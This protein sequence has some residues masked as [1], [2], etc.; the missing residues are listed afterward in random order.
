MKKHILYLA[1]LSVWVGGAGG[2]AS[3]A[4]TDLLAKGQRENAKLAAFH[5]ARFVAGTFQNV[6]A[7]YIDTT[8]VPYQPDDQDT[9]AIA[10]NRSPIGPLIQGL[11]QRMG[12][13]VMFTADTDPGQTVSINLRNIGRRAAIRMTAL[14]AGDVA[15]IQDRERR[16]IVAKQGTY[17]FKLPVDLFSDTKAKYGVGGNPAAGGSQSGG[18]APMGGMPGMGGAM[19]GSSGAPGQSMQASFVISG[20][21]GGG[22]A[23]QFL[24]NVKELAGPGAKVSANWITGLL[25]VTAAPAPLDRVRSFVNDFVQDALTQVEIQTTIAEVSLSDGQQFGIDW[26]RIVP[27]AGNGSV[28]FSFNNSNAVSSTPAFTTTITTASISSVVKALE[29]QANV[30]ILAK[31]RLLALNH[32]PANLFDGQQQP[33]LGSANTATTGLSGT[34][35]TGASLSYV[36]NGVSLSFLPN[37]LDN[38][39]V[40]LRIVPVLS[41]VAQF[42]DFSLNGTTLTGPQQLLR[43]VYMQ[44]LAQNG[45]TLILGG[46]HVSNTSLGHSGV[47]ILDR[48]PLLGKLFTGINDNGSQKELVLLVSTHVIPAPQHQTLIGET[49]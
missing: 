2:C 9:V 43:Q 34:V 1:L 10:S 14:A 45:K 48:I 11:A 31:P 4:N 32:T 36:L 12:Y 30:R 21:A 44:V 39:T 38:N 17:T 49:L 46:T 29:Q 33:Y 23:D 24:A 6:N 35:S 19:G 47:P 41:D 22:G 42:K 20:S 15:L 18:G 16:I 40:S 26:S 8:P 27:I 25:S 28:Q 37:I 13:S 5:R 3:T 7:P